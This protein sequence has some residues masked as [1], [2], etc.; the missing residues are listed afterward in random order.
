MTKLQEQSN[1]QTKRGKWSVAGVPHKGWVCVDIEDLRAPSL[2]CEMCESQQIRFIH[3]MEHPNY[4]DVLQVGC[5]CAGHMEGNLAASRARETCMQNRAAKRKRWTSRTW[6]TSAK[7]NPYISAD[8]Y[9]VT[10]YPW[11]GGWRSSVV[12]VGSTDVQRSR[13]TFKTIDAAKL[14]A[15][16]HITKLLAGGRKMA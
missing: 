6:K 9:R 3:H 13:R 11:G 5:D 10:V 1:T 14:A 16:D 4:P 2:Q 8:G 15:F 7:G 12:K